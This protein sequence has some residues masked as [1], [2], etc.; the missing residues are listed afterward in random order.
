M[1]SKNYN[2]PS[3]LR[4][5]PE[6]KNSDP[7]RATRNLNRVLYFQNL[8]RELLTQAY[9]AAQEGRPLDAWCYRLEAENLR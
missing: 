1:Q 9:V 5:A 6:T 7:T 3:D 2:T 8:R 4:T